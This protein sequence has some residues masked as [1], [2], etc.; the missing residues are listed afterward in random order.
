MR[1]YIL[2]LL[3]AR[4]RAEKNREDQP[5]LSAWQRFCEWVAEWV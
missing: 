1:R 5:T 3:E 2:G 4:V